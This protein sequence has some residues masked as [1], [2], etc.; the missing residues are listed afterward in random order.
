VDGAVAKYFPRVG[1]LGSPDVQQHTDGWLYA[2]ITSGT[3]V[4][5]AYGHELDSRERWQIVRFVRTL[6][7]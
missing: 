6:A 2:L 5:P 1:D 7:R 3:P 4:M